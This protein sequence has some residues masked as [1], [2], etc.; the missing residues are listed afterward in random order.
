VRPEGETDAPPVVLRKDGGEWKIVLAESVPPEVQRELLALH[1][2][3]DELR[4]RGR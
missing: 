4:R 1:R 2:R 3:A